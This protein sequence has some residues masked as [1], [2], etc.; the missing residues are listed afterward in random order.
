MKR[1]RATGQQELDSFHPTDRKAWRAWL[2][3]NHE[4]SRGVW[5]V[6]WRASTGKPRIGY[7]ASI[8]EALCFGWI[9]GLARTIDADRYARRFTPRAEDSQW[10]ALN[11]KRVQ[12]ALETAG[13][14][15]PAGRTLAR[16]PSSSRRRCPPRRRDFSPRS[17]R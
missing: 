4:S 14:M 8:E 1:S 15:A 10:S 17:A 2:S 6:Y 12:R 3:R 5:L 7:D 16:R 13:L 9:D 11:L